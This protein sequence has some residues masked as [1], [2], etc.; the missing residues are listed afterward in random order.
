MKNNR[1]KTGLFFVLGFVSGMVVLSCLA[2][3]HI[4]G[5]RDT[6]MGSFVE[7]TGKGVGEAVKSAMEERRDPVGEGAG[8]FTTETERYSVA[9]EGDGTGGRKP[10]PYEY[11]PDLMDYDVEDTIY[12]KNYYD[13]FVGGLV[14]HMD[15]SPRM[16]MRGELDDYFTDD[17]EIFQLDYLVSMFYDDRTVEIDEKELEQLFWDHGYLLSLHNAEYKDYHLRFVEITEKNGLSLYPFRILMQTWDDDSIYLQDITSIVPRKIGDLMVVDD[18]DVWK[19]IVHSTGLSREMVV[20]E[21]LSFW[22]FTGT[23]WVLVPMELRIDT[24]NAHGMGISSYPDLD[25]DELFEAVYYRD[26]ITFHPSRQSMNKYGDKWTLR[27]GVMEVI[28]ENRKFRLIPVCRAEGR[29]VKLAGIYIQCT[30]K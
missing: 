30:I 6:V 21:E 26:G 28:E 13:N 11:V 7:D 10:M 17:S 24:S 20:E 4:N 16:E 19:M 9:G 15:Y 23:Y 14:E 1:Y 18:G 8:D 12:Y 5:G 27:L 22:E 3:G 2:T 29:M 25:R